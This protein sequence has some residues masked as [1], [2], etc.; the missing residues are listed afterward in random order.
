MS[1]DMDERF[2]SLQCSVA[3]GY[4][5]LWPII[6]RSVSVIDLVNLVARIANEENQ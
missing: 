1:G 3:R 4:V 2:Y 5:E 6:P